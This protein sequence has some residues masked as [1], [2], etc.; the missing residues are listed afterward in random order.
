MGRKGWERRKWKL[1]NVVS[2]KEVGSE[3]CKRRMWVG[4]GWE[5]GF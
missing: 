1:G 3:G 5:E 4:V 2:K